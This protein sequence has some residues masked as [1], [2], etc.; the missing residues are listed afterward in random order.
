MSAAAARQRALGRLEIEVPATR[1]GARLDQAL[2]VLLPDQ[3]R[4]ALQRLIRG[5]L[6]AVD[7]GPARPAQRLRGGERIVVELPPPQPS[8][9]APEELRLEILHEDSDLLVINKPAG[10]TVHPGAGVRSGTLV[11][12]LLHHCRD[13]SGIGGVERPGIVHRL[14]RDTSGAIVVAKNDLAHRSLAAQFKGRQVRKIYEAVVWGR[15]RAAAGIVDAPVGRHP[16]ARVRMAVRQDGRAA[17][18]S[19]KILERLGSVTLLELRPETG[20][21]HQI[22][23][24]LQSLGHPI[25]GDRVYGGRRA[26]AGLPE[27]TRDALAAYNGLALHARSLEFEHPRSGKAMRFTAPRPEALRVMI[28][29]LR[30]GAPGRPDQEVP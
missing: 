20:R 8:G 10:L 25:V 22:R 19:W 16:T 6:V 21:T 29:A 26:L 7:G 27:P 3:S 2:A 17:R 13:L 24:H 18:T 5:G 15:P 11:N 28:D 23:V 14:D 1:A 12:A 30:A 4:A 9:L